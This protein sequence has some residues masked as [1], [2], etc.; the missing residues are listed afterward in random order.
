MGQAAHQMPNLR[1]EIGG[2]F[3]VSRTSAALGDLLANLGSSFAGL[4]RGFFGGGFAAASLLL[5]YIVPR[6]LF[7][8]Q[9]QRASSSPP[10]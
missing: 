1:E 7:A 6:H 3:S 10:S 4:E 5:E 9:L 8:P 2:V